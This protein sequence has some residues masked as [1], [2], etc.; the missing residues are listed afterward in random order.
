MARSA[1]SPRDLHGRGAGLTGHGGW[2][3]T[4]WLTP[5][6]EAVL[7]RHL[8]SRRATAI[9]ARRSLPHRAEPPRADLARSPTSREGVDGT[10][11]S[12]HPRHSRTDAGAEG[13]RAGRAHR[14][15]RGDALQRNLDPEQGGAARAQVPSSMPVRFLLRQAAAED[16]PRRS[17]WEP[18]SRD[19][20]GRHVRPRR[21]RLPSLLDRRRV[22]RAAFE[23]ML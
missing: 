8:L 13:R 16:F 17:T 23:K 1:P 14:P 21:R 22:A 5:D 10:S 15:R 18:R 19:G 2:P 4:T 11:R 3:M 12:S 9:A 7:R 20:R 6:R